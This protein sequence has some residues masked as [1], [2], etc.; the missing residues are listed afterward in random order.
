MGGKKADGTVERKKVEMAPHA[1]T[2]GEGARGPAPR[3]WAGRL[4]GRGGRGRHGAHLGLERAEHVCE[5]RVLPSQGE[6]PLLHHRAL[7]VIVHQNHVFLQGFYSEKLIGFLE[8]CQED[9]EGRG[10]GVVL[11]WNLNLHSRKERLR[12]ERDRSG[13]ERSP[14]QPSVPFT[15]TK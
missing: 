15:D 6:N 10:G 11:F 13:E 9:L 4:W 3:A 12:P 5:E 14:L 8:L 1:S 7:H 2:E